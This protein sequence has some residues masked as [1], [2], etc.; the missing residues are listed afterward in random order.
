MAHN[1]LVR[2]FSTCRIF[3]YAIIFYFRYILYDYI[4]KNEEKSYIKSFPI[5][6]G[7]LLPSQYETEEG[8]FLYD[9]FY[10][11]YLLKFYTDAEKIV[12]Y[13][14][15][16]VLGIPLNVIIFDDNEEEILQNFKWEEGKGLN[17]VDEINLLNRKNHYEIIYT[18]SDNEKY[19]NIFEN[20]ENHKK[21]VVLNDIEKH[22]NALAKNSNTDIFNGTFDIKEKEK[23]NNPKT[24]VLKGNNLYNIDNNLVFENNNTNNNKIELNSNNANQNIKDEKKIN[25]NNKNQ[26]NNNKNNLNPNV[27]IKQKNDVISNIIDYDNLD[28]TNNKMQNQKNNNNNNNNIKNINNTNMTKN[29]VKKINNNQIYNLNPPNNIKQIP[30][31]NNIIQN[32]SKQNLKEKPNNQVN[33]QSIPQDNIELNTNQ[34]GKQNYT[35]STF[36][37]KKLSSQK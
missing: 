23:I 7:N 5:K 8:K 37:T 35:K 36:S 30:D 10:T 15:P 11:N 27:Q 2:S 25:N 32:T 26:K 13:L 18:L 6:L 14:T 19:K 9:L 12:I 33:N 1:T 16:F 21:S 20:Y 34:I 3:D 31:K 4:K 28:V 29:D 24:M 22:L 17:I